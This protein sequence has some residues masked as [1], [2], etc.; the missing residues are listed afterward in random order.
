MSLEIYPNYKKTFLFPVALEE[1][2]PMDHPA[3]FIRAF[4]ESLDLKALGFNQRTA[5]QGR[6]N[7]AADMLLKIW[8]YGFYMKIRSSRK[9]EQACME[10]TGLLWLTG[11]NYP[12]HNTI[13]RF[14]KKN[15]NAIKNVFK[16]SLE[17][18]GSMGLVGMVLHAV[19]GTKIRADVS[20]QKALHR[21]DLQ[22]KLDQIDAAIAEIT[23]QI[24]RNER[25]DE[26]QEYKLPDTFVEKLNDHNALRD[27]IAEKLE[28]LAESKRDH[29]SPVDNDARMMKNGKATDFCFNAQVA[30][31][32]QSGLIVG[33]EVVSDE[34][35]NYVLDTV[36]DNVEATLGD[37][38][39]TSVTDGGYYSGQTLADAEKKDRNVVMN[40]SGNHDSYHHKRSREFHHTKFTYHQDGDYYEC[41]IGGTLRFRRI[42]MKE[43]LS[44]SVRQ[45]RCLDYRDCPFRY[46][47]SKDKQGRS[48]EQSPYSD[49]I[50]R[51]RKKQSSDENKALLSKR[52]SIVELVFG[53]I[54]HNWGFRRWTV[55]GLENVKTQWS[56]ICTTYNLMKLYSHWVNSGVSILQKA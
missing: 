30:V 51:Q 19:D 16:Q 33:S 50:E 25:N 52:K 48:I 39:D 11:M 21:R 45:Y 34:C 2:V 1:F 20:N 44:Y 54:K 10:M 38:A 7:Y 36:L 17:L 49:V 3:R 23:L 37:T 27:E 12:D 24:V 46:Q 41:P 9:L 56:L 43:R 22:A 32:D 31:D 6:P 14:F 4:V 5:T 53:V 18:A 15:R 13:W 35:D 42:K 8:L 29:Q 55:R 26:G 47:C 40:L 28:Q